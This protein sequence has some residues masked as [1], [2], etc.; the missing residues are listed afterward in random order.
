MKLST[1]ERDKLPDEVFGLP[2]TR[3]YPL[4]DE[5]H[6]LQA[7]RMFKYVDNV[8]DRHTL[9]KNI[10][11][12]AKELGMKFEIDKYPNIKKYYSE[13]PMDRFY[14]L[15]YNEWRNTYGVWD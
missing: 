7:I 4:H 14:S 9:A 10:V 3:Q 1:K 8:E 2:K 13:S 5:S 11:R 12:R 6:V 15:F